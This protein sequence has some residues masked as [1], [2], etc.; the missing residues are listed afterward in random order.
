[1]LSATFSPQT[2]LEF[3]SL[4]DS[5]NE[6]RSSYCVKFTCPVSSLFMTFLETRQLNEKH[7]E[8]EAILFYRNKL[9]F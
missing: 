1:M 7:Q 4:P 8:Q 2:A 6:I 9:L 5:P 3:A